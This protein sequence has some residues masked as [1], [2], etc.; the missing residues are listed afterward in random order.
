MSFQIPLL[1]EFSLTAGTLEGFH[2]VV[3]ERVSLQAVQREEALGALAAH[4]RTFPR[5]RAR[6]HV[7]V[8]LAGETLPAVR[9][10]VR[11]LAR[12][13]PGVQQQLPGGQKGLPAR[14]A[15]VVLLPFVH[16]HVSRNSSFAEAFPADG[17]QVGGALVQALVLLERIVAEESLV[18]LAAGE[19]PSPLVEPLVLVITRRAGESLLALVAAV[20]EAVELHVS[21]QLIWKFK[22]FWAF[23]AFSFF[24][25]K[26][27]VDSPRAEEP[28][29]FPRV[30][31]GSLLF[32]VF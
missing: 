17:A 5:V 7:Q 13:R 20:R 22:N 15:Q 2:P 25:C 14:G 26:V 28:L 19:Y 16:L 31:C 1:G 12:V 4:V 24:I 10:G 23:Q 6:V 8:A 27:F 3:A 30:L 11:H 9:A 21:L 32:L 18:A 29:V